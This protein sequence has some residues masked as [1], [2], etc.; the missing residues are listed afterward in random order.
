MSARFRPQ[1]ALVNSKVLIDLTYGKNALFVRQTTAAAFGIP[2]GWEFTWADLGDTICSHAVEAL[3]SQVI[4]D[5]LSSLSLRVPSEARAFNEF[6]R[7]LAAAH[8]SVRIR[9]QIC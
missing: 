2:L 1:T 4:V 6:L 8:P 3:P 5:G 7:R 9:I